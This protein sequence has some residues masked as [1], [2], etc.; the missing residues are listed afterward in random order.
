MMTL[1]DGQTRRLAAG[2]GLSLLAFGAFSIVAPRPFAR[3]FGFH[4]P[5]AEAITMLRSIG[6][7]DVAMGA[8]LAEAAARGKPYAAWL[9]ARAV[10]DGGDAAAISIA[11]TQGKHDARFMALGGMALAATLADTALWALARR[12]PSPPAPHPE[13]EGSKNPLTRRR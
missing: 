9:L 3:L 10:A 1:S 11:A 13:G 8:G 12:K 5:D 2:L 6:M 4:E 7:R